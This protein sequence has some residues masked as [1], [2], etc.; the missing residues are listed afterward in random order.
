MM[1]EY[2]KCLE[3]IDSIKDKVGAMHGLFTATEFNFYHSLSLSS[4][5][6]DVDK[7][8]AGSYRK[9]IIL[10][11]LAMKEWSERCPENFL[12]KYLL[13]QAELSGLDGNITD[14][15]N[16]YDRAISSAGENK[17]I[18]N[19]ALCNELAA[20][21]WFS[22]GKEE[23]AGIYLRKARRLYSEWGALRKVRM[24]DWVYP[25]L[26]RIRSRSGGYDSDDLTVINRESAAVVRSLQAISGEIEFDSLLHTLTSNILQFSGATRLVFMME[27][28]GMMCVGSEG[29]L[30][31]PEGSIKSELLHSVPL[32]TYHG[33]PLGVIRYCRRTGDT[34]IVNDGTAD[35]MFQ[36][37][38]YIAM[39]MPKS[40][41]CVKNNYGD[42]TVMTYLENSVAR[43]AFTTG[44]VDVLKL[45]SVQAAISLE[46]ARLYREK[47]ESVKKLAELGE[48]RDTL[49]KQYD[50]AQQ[51]AMQK[52]MDPHFL[53][54]AIHT[55]HSLININPAEADR[56]VLLLGEMLH[57][58]TDRSFE[59]LVAFN[60]EWRFIQLYLEFEKI[61]F[62]DTLWFFLEKKY[63][64]DGIM[65]PPLTIQPLVENAIKHGLR[66]KSGGGIVNITAYKMDDL[67]V[68]EVRDT[69]IGLNTDDLY[70]RSIGNI[71]N[72]LKYNFNFAD[73]TLSS[74]ENGGV[75]VTVKFTARNQ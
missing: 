55:I 27:E 28:A 51:R 30:N 73:V 60:D 35:E 67:A 58:F 7:A 44:K 21:F 52:R 49:L 1:A 75:K 70:S 11:Q 36:D 2:A 18:Q 9:E 40:Y 74:R 26:I 37:D 32:D 19:E 38:P 15:M 4:M 71:I 5:I 14:A 33:V 64:F 48:I 23:F 24:I 3:I 72:R 29:S 50:E 59:R 66:K 31:S 8:T 54:N 62:P 12:H 16:Y 47:K 39:N 46:N 41:I 25:A 34:V 17:Y 61:R 56:A 69:G 20:R 45:I 53:Y 57:F 13:V 10:N 63:S 22:R 43:Y 6:N 65:I 42:T 68:I